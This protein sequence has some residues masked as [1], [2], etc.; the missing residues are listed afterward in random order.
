MQCVLYNSTLSLFAYGKYHK[1]QMDEK[2]ENF[3]GKWSM[4][5]ILL[6]SLSTLIYLLG[7]SYIFLVILC[8]LHLLHIWTCHSLDIFVDCLSDKSSLEFFNKIFLVL[9]VDIFT[10]QGRRRF[11]WKWSDDFGMKNSFWNPKVYPHCSGNDDWS[12]KSRK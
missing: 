12:L 11:K 10:G 8:L 4:Y 5:L 2:N 6:S 9:C 1:I 7:C 3:W